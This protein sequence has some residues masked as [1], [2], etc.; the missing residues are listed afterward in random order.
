MLHYSFTPAVTGVN[1]NEFGTGNY[2]TPDLHY[3]L[4]NA[5]RIGVLWV[6]RNPD[7]RELSAWRPPDDKW[8]DLTAFLL[9]LRLAGVLLPTEFFSSDI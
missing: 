4:K 2:V 5:G 1:I 8:K 9:R 6:F 7:I 3:A